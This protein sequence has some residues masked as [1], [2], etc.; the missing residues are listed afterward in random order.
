MGRKAWIQSTMPGDS[1]GRLNGWE[2]RSSEGLFI[3]LF[4]DSCWLSTRGLDSAPYVLPHVV[5]LW[6]KICLLAAWWLASSG[7]MIGDK[8][9]GGMETEKE[10]KK[11]AWRKRT[12]ERP[13]H[14][15]YP[16]FLSFQFQFISLV[17]EVRESV[18][19]WKLWLHFFIE[20][21][22]G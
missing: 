4:L 2:Q 21:M 22:M 14:C 8:R 5:S 9:E 3:C 16:E 6:E 12:R 1:V 7:F 13:H 10:R 18:W 19:R 20:K 17:V 15:F 11:R